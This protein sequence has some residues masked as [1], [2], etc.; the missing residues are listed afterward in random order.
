[1]GEYAI[2]LAALIISMTTLVLNQI[3]L[4]RAASKSYASEL[5]DRLANHERRLSDCERQKADMIATLE[6]T[7]QLLWEALAKNREK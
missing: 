6:E 2:P 7:R 4:R 3:G 1:M 5:A